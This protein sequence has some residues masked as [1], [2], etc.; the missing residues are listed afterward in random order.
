MAKGCGGRTG[1]CMHYVWWPSKAYGYEPEPDVRVIYEGPVDG[2]KKADKPKKNVVVNVKPVS[3]YHY[4]AGM[5]VN[6]AKWG[7]CIID[8]ISE[9]TIVVKNSIGNSFKLDRKTVYE[10]TLL[11]PV[12][13]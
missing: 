3:R 11:V 8:W 2:Y 10:R 7:L 1:A 6:H 4:Y 13:S 12:R 9:K 5:K